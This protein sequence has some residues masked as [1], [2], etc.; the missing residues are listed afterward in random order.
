MD[1]FKNSARL[2]KTAYF[3]LLSL[4]G[5]CHVCA[6]ITANMIDL[7]TPSGT[8][9]APLY[10]IDSDAENSGAGYTRDT[11][12]GGADVEFIRSFSFNSESGTYRLKAQ[13]IDSQGNPMD[14][15]GGGTYAY[16]PSQIVNFP[17][18]ST[19]LTRSFS[20]NIDPD[21][22]LGAGM[23][24]TIRYWVQ[25]FT[26]IDYYGTPISIWTNTGGDGPGD[27]GSFVVVHFPDL[28]ENTANRNARGWLRG[29]PTWTKT[30]AVASGTTTAQQRFTATVPYSL[31][32][33]DVGGS[34]VSIAVRFTATLTDDTG[35]V[36][37]LKNGGVSSGSFTRHAHA[38]SDPDSPYLVSGNQTVTVI[39]AVQLD[40]ANHTYK[41]AVRFEHLETS[42][43]G[44]RDDGTSPATALTRLLHFNGTLRFGNVAAAFDSISNSPLAGTH[45]ANYIETTLNTLAGTLHL[46]PDYGFGAGAALSVR[47]ESDGDARVT[48][49]SRVVEVAGGGDV[50]ATFGGITVTYPGTTLNA[51]GASS[52]STVVHLPQG[53]GY[54][55]ARSTSAGRYAAEITLPGRSLDSQLRHS[56]TLSVGTSADAWVFDEARPLLYRVSSFGFTQSGEMQFVAAEA[57]WVHKAAFDQLEADAANGDHQ[58]ASMSY[59]LTN[60]GYLRFAKIDSPRQVVFNTPADGSVR[61]EYAELNVHPGKFLTHFPLDTQLQWSDTNKI[62]IVDGQ[63]AQSSW[64]SGAGTISVAYDGSCAGDG[65]GPPPGSAVANITLYPKEGELQLTPDG[66]VYAGGSIDPKSL[67]WGIR[68]D[69]LA[70]H[71]T[72]DFS[73]AEFLAPGCQLYESSN[74]IA[75]GGPLASVSG[76]LAP[77]S[78][79]LA[80]YD[81]TGG[82][83]MVYFGTSQYTDGDGA[84][85]GAT[86]VVSGAGAVGGSRLADMTS[87]YDYT[88]QSDVSKYYVRRSGVSGRH[89]AEQGSFDSDAILY[90]YAFQ[91]TRFQLTYLSNENEKSWINGSIE[92]TKPSG[93]EQQF[94]SLTL[95]CTG[96]LDQAEIDPNDAGSKPLYYWNGSFEP[97]AMRFAPAAG[98]GCYAQRFLA[99]G[100][101]SGA[102]NI[103]TPLAGSLAFMPTGNIATLADHIEGIDGRLGLPA[104]LEMAG[105]GDEIYQLTPV[106]KL[107]FNNPDVSGAPKSGYVSFAARCNVPFFE[108][109]K[110]HVMTSAAA[111]VPAP[112]YLAAGWSE[113]GETYFSNVNFDADNRGFPPTGI[114]VDNYRQPSSK[115]AFVPVA[116]QS[117]FGLVPLSYPLKWSPSGRYFSSWEAVSND[118][119]VLNVEHQ[120]DYLS[121]DNAEISFGAQ[122]E[123]LPEI[124]LASAAVEVVGERVGAAGALTDAAS[125]YVTDTLNR[126][127]DEIG[128]LTS[129]NLEAVLDRALDSIQGQVITPLYTAVRQSYDDAAVNHQS[130]GNWVN[131]SSGSLKSKF[132]RYLDGSVGVAAD[133]VKGRLNQLYNSADDASN[134]IARVQDAVENGILAIDSITGNLEVIDGDVVFNLNPPTASDSGVSELI[135]GLLAKIANP[136]TSKLERRILQNL[137]GQLIHQL[138]PADLAAVLTTATGDLTAGL[139]GEL[140]ELLAD[141]DPTLDRVTEAL[142]EARAYLVEI[143]AELQNGKEIFASFQEI[144]TQASTEI[145][146]I[147]AEIRASAYG[148]INDMAQAAN[149]GP[150]TVLDTT[151]DLFDEFTEEEFVGM[152][153]AELRDRLLNAAFIQQ[154]QY[155]LRQQISEL[156]MALHSAIDSA[157]SEASRMC[158]ALVK[159]SLG[160][161]DDAINGLTGDVNAYAGAGSV[162]G[163][164]HIQGD[165]LRRL[166]LDAQLQLKVPK[167][168]E[169]QAFIEMKCYDSATDIDSG[170]C[171]AAGSQTV[172][173]TMGA[174]DVPLD[175]VSPDMR[176]NVEARFAMR[177]SPTV[178]PRGIGGAI[179]MTGGELNFQSF[180]ITAFAASMAVGLDE[181]YLAATARMVISSYEAA[182]G[183]F[184]GKTCSIEPLEMVDPEV[185]SLLG[186]P[187]FTG[188]YVYGEVWIPISE[189]VLGVPASCLFRISAGV[190]AGAFY[191]VQGP[192]YGGK[193]LLGVSGEALCVVSIRGELA[194]TGVMSGGS[195]R[196][197]GRGKLKG[198]A[199]YCPFCVKFSENANV[200]YQDGDWSV[201]Y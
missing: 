53:L 106:T 17:A 27:T 85:A 93:F 62:E 201:D 86:M 191:F 130:Y 15:S 159:K 73:S 30:F 76:V 120:V 110:V 38:G 122:Y 143:R 117:L 147:I 121:A 87:D 16:G 195:L 91:I 167:E 5:I 103:T 60:D 4:G 176:A 39:P 34:T 50:A 22:D 105:P 150:D 37:P 148:F 12:S 149:Y 18:Y 144:I 56:G 80:G 155:V 88:L 9:T 7:V 140:N 175:W 181:C 68:G 20:V 21:E 66:G 126:G 186:T 42:P 129:D 197:K 123:G 154:I 94:R 69:G 89:V 190:G 157:F 166:R 84:Y 51:S 77:G 95:T 26:T 8:P 71:H 111:A 128:A 192:T 132:D 1:I 44:Y 133:S 160:P 184:F 118:L 99:L 168:M 164:A 115:N 57:E 100:L 127:V 114:T 174:L 113:S 36:V 11:I 108:D 139:N 10:V 179:E 199:G 59:R 46:S 61:T 3:L 162:D 151:G 29:V 32:R 116:H 48:G 35:A 196:F 134:L 78:L 70:A 40:S 102:A 153:R 6:G 28:P 189:V 161:I 81:A 185:S 97:I 82:G 141:F 79:L 180:K 47:L 182:G 171:I 142:Q 58:S 136:D 75:S 109:L 49:G 104:A 45:G 125:Q 67:K 63:L 98:G 33:Y 41:L 96:A 124:N 194:M 90:G 138:A 163:Y 25:K 198:K 131:A 145:D 152:I 83:A 178:S 137:V 55:S 54:T 64:L 172:E 13:L 119:L 74:P 14:L 135:H 19:E 92:V 23:S 24:Y 52:G 177:T 183:I 65:C 188:A 169:L 193:M 146:T 107:Y 72:D 2:A 187:P 101:V 31:A 112:V 158:K 165:T 170:G 156:D 43:G 200:T 173:V